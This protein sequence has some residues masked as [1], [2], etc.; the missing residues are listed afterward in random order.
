MLV[1]FMASLCS[2]LRSS[3]GS[4]SRLIFSI[5]WSPW[6]R[7]VGGGGSG[8]SLLNKLVG[9]PDLWVGSVLLAAMEAG[10]FV[11][12]EDIWVLL[13][14][15]ST[16][17]SW[18][19]LVVVGLERVMRKKGGCSGD[20]LRIWPEWS[21]EV[22]GDLPRPIFNSGLY[23][24]D[25]GGWFLRFVKKLVFD[26]VSSVLCKRDGR[27]LHLRCG[28]EFGGRRRRSVQG[29]GRTF[30]MFFVFPG[31]FVQFVQPRC[32][33]MFLVCVHVGCNLFTFL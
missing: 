15:S 33:R 31:C 4:S 9:A 2:G 7:A 10:E 11:V 18:R 16:G 8:K 28:I 20:F 6:W 27:L 5:W 12:A 21:S 25:C 30:L 32:L 14:S 1:V 13:V 22:A 24:V 3:S 19:S 23:S 17:T 26:G 29:P